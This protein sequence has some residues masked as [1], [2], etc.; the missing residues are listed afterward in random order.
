[1]VFHRFLDGSAGRKVVIS[2][3]GEKLQPWDPF[4]TAEPG[5]VQLTKQT[6]EIEAGEGS[7]QVSLRRWVLPARNRFSQPGEFDRA[8]GPLKWNRQQGL[9][10]YRAERLVQWGGWAGLRAIDEHTKLARCA[11]EF[12]TD[13]DAAFNI[14]VAKMRV[15]LPLMLRPLLE[16]P[17]QEVCQAAE[18]AYRSAGESSSRSRTPAPG[19]SG[20]SLDAE[21]G[22]ALLSAAVQVDQVE[23]LRDIAAVLRVQAPELARDL[24]LDGF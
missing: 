18:A 14:N 21:A 22:L 17:V 12:G 9:Y 6:F 15:T 23:A 10:I 3:N 5:T 16:R 8:A 19:A 24:N 2:L 13:L 11:L 1:M 4:A 7:G 20:R